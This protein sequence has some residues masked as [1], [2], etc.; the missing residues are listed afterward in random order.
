MRDQPTACTATDVQDVV[1][2]SYFRGPLGLPFTTVSHVCIDHLADGRLMQSLYT[3]AALVQPILRSAR[4]VRGN[5][6]LNG[7][8]CT[9]VQYI[10]AWRAEQAQRPQFTLDAWFSAYTITT[11]MVLPA[12]GAK[13]AHWLSPIYRQA[14]E[15]LFGDNPHGLCTAQ[16]RR[17]Q[18]IHDAI[19]VLH[20][21]AA[22][23]LTEQTLNQTLQAQPRFVSNPLAAIAA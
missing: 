19:A 15:R 23:G 8:A 20:G 18:D 5:L 4:C 9:S 21:R 10:A 16:I 22:Y 11:S 14:C 3:G 12:R 2:M 13:H 1:G 7:L 6:V 17:V